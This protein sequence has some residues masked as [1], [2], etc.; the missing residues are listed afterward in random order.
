MPED[1]NLIADFEETVKPNKTWYIDFDKN[2]VTRSITDLEAIR[3]AATLILA[4]ERF[5]FIIYSNQYGVELVDL[6]GENQPYVMSEIKRRVTEALTQDDRI[7]GVE[8]FSYTRTKRS[9]H[10]TFTVVTKVG[11]FNAETEVAL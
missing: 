11:Q 8:N 5:E 10:V 6:F 4:T 2:L 3:Q 1:Y 7:R 9:L